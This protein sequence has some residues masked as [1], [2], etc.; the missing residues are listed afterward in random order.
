MQV[1]I[2]TLK[3]TLTRTVENLKFKINVLKKR[4]DLIE[5]IL[6]KHLHVCRDLDLQ[7]GNIKKRLRKT[8]D[9]AKN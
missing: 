2:V 8:K 3:E 1:R 5:F 7:L 9:E 6:F 4:H